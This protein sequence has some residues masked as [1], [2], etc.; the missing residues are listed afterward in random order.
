MKADLSCCFRNPFYWL[1]L[2]TEL[3]V[4]ASEPILISELATMCADRYPQNSGIN[5]LTS[6]PLPAYRGLSS[7]SLISNV[8]R[9]FYGFKLNRKRITRT[10]FH[11]EPVGSGH[12]VTV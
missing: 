10:Q 9:A 2:S 11:L 8:D 4:R 3:S 7:G 12:A 5:S 6:L 1:V